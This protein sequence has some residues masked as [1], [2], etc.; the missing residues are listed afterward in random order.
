MSIELTMALT[1]GLSFIL[2][3]LMSARQTYQM[4]R[5]HL[6][7][8][9]RKDMFEYNARLISLTEDLIVLMR[10]AEESEARLN[11]EI[12][13]LAQRRSEDA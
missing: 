11:A 8:R 4:A 5:S 1:A 13:R 9:H 2:G 6:A 10:N 3:V 12:D 7:K